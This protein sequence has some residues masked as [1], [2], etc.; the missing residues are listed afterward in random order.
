M[1]D[2]TTFEITQLSPQAEGVVMSQCAAAANTHVLVTPKR[3]DFQESKSVLLSAFFSCA[4]NSAVKL[5]GCWLCPTR[6]RMVEV[7][8]MDA[9][10]PTPT[11][12]HYQTH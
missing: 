11:S 1:I 5:C 3:F 4:G 10:L 7:E 6:A 9:P 2:P 8:L 12:D